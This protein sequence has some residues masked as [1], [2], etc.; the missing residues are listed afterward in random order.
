MSKDQSS[1][2][3]RF[4]TPLV[5][6]AVGL[7][8]LLTTSGYNTLMERSIKTAGFAL[9]TIGSLTF[10]IIYNHSRNPLAT[11]KIVV[12]ISQALVVYG[13]IL[14]TIVFEAILPISTMLVAVTAVS[15][16]GVAVSAVVEFTN[17]KNSDI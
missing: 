4:V 17:I 16:F 8:I 15:I 1:S 11:D 5:L 13:G 14:T 10:T 6:L 12:D 2:F 7:A 9:Y 3:V